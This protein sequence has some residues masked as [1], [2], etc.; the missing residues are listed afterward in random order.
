MNERRT[1]SG[2]RPSERDAWIGRLVRLGEVPLA[3]C[4]DGSVKS[5][6]AAR[7][8]ADRAGYAPLEVLGR[9]FA[10]AGAWIGGPAGVANA[11]EEEARRRMRDALAA[12]LV[13][14]TSADGRFRCGF[15]GGDQPLVDAALLALGL[16]RAGPAFWEALD[17][18]E[19]ERTLVALEQARLIRPWHNNW[20]L[21]SATLEA[22]LATKG[23]R[24][25]PGRIRHALACHER[26]YLGDGIYSD[27]ATIGVD[28]YNGGTI[29]PFLLTLVELDG[30]SGRF[31]PNAM[32]A[33]ILERARRHALTL[34][35]LV[36]ADGSFPAVG[37]S[38]SYRCGA[39]HLLGHLAWR[40]Q[41]PATLSPARVRGCLG[42]AI[43]WTLDAPHTV[44]PEGWLQVGL[45][46]AQPD[47]ADR[48]SSGGSG[49]YCLTAFAPLGLPASDPFWSDPDAAWSAVLL[50][51]GESPGPDPRLT[52][53]TGFLGKVARNLQLGRRW[54]EL[55]RPPRRLPRPDGP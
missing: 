6:M 18:A 17:R 29:Q 14:A 3:A 42:A 28:H 51:R 50:G 5:A 24:Y 46:G 2:G 13:A 34:E 30:G 37:R 35:R 1:E 22:F 19:R 31:V 49:Y 23:R 54:H 38:V 7:S 20:L 11:R 48:Y 33:R 43:A 26:W 21:F 32:Q 53:P 41:L 27:G 39:F 52:K 8:R 4:A 55:I 9:I 47:L 12:A 10:G 15:S 36:A 40:G 44:D 45:R 16:F 25:R